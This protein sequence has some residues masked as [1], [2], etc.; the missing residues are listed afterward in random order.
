[1]LFEWKIR[2]ENY[3]RSKFSFPLS[4][5]PVLVLDLNEK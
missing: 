1:M 5:I 3:A 2:F 4:L